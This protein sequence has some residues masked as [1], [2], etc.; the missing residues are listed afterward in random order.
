[1]MKRAIELHRQKAEIEK[2]AGAPASS[3]RSYGWLRRAINFVCEWFR[4][5]RGTPPA[6][7]SECAVLAA[8][9]EQLEARVRGLEE[10]ER[11]AIP[12]RGE[13]ALNL[14]TRSAA[15]KLASNG[16]DAR[17]IAKAVGVPVGEISLLL[18]VERLANQL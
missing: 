11:P 6:K 17:Q 5:S 7:E 18:K 15:L 3:L 1:M 14:T 4:R 12:R 16:Q 9:I 8:R 2:A 10:R 13:M